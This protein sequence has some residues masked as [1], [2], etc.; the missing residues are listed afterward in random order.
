[1]D[2]KIKKTYSNKFKLKVAL[3]ALKED[4]TVNEMCQEFAVTSGRIYEWKKQ[5][6][7]RGDEIF[8]TKN[9]GLIRDINIEKIHSI[10]GKLIIERELL[11]QKY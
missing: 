4:K 6:E 1:M 9:N 5:L 2:G 11:A 10:I 8:A 7:A 3:A